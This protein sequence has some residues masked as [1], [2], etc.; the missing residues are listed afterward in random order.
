MAGGFTIDEKNISNFRDTL[1]NSFSKSEAA[2][3][4]DL[5]LYLDTVIAPSAINEDFF[6]EINY[7]SPFGSGNNEPKFVVE[8]IK[9]VSSKIVGR[10]HISSILVG[11][12]GTTFKGFLWNGVNSSLEPFLNK[13]NKKK[14]DIAGRLR[15]NNW[16][17]FI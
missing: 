9:V 17:G 15:E 16:K 11:K 7:L 12:D 14:I 4:K 13:K 8:D 1:I 5:A 6:E 2:I 10:D 3:P